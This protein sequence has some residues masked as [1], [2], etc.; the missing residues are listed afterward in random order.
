MSHAT[1]RH[2]RL[3]QGAAPTT[4]AA[5][6]ANSAGV[7]NAA[8]ASQDPRARLAVSAAGR[9]PPNRAKIPV[10]RPA[11]TTAP[12][13]S[14]ASTRNR[15]L[16]SVAATTT[17]AAARQATCTRPVVTR[18]AD[19]RS[20]GTAAAEPS[21]HRRATQETPNEQASRRPAAISRITSPG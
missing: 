15:R 2:G 4:T 17:A 1:R 13:A 18:P 6:D 10:A 21:S 8:P 11:A 12:A 20:S 5:A 16:R 9:W 7:G 14:P 19:P 3:S